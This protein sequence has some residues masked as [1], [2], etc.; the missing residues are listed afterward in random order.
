[1][2][3]VT[4]SDTHTMHD[5]IT[6]PDGDILIHSGDATNRGYENEVREFGEWFRNQPHKYKVFVAGNHD[7]SFEDTP[8]QARQWFFDEEVDPTKMYSKNGAF[9]LQEQSITLT[10]GNESVN[11]YGAPHQPEFCNWAF[12]VK[13]GAALKAIWDKIPKDTD[14][15]IT[16]GPSYG[17]RD[18]SSR[19]IKCGCRD[20]KNAVG[21]VRPKLHVFGHIHEGYGT[22]QWAGTL[23]ANTSICDARYDP[24]NKPLIFE[25]KDGKVYKAP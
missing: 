18:L 9:Y 17:V 1:M 8:I 5:Q 13:P 25:F 24:V 20:L 11:I 22:E 15:L 16:H 3:V 19:G 2:K 12:N 6:V 23:V 4:I 10:I 7:T 21:R 14:I